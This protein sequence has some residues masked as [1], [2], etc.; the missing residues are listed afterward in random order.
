MDVNCLQQLY[1]FIPLEAPQTH[2]TP[3]QSKHT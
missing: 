1:Y 2:L 3:K